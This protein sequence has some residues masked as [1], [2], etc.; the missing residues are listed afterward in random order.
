MEGNQGLEYELQREN[1]GG[2][3]PPRARPRP[4]RPVRAPLLRHRRD[5]LR[6]AARLSSGCAKRPIDVYDPVQQLA[7]VDDDVLDMFGVDTD[8]TGPRLRAGRRMLGGVDVCPTARHAGCRLGRCRSAPGTAGSSARKAGPRHRP[9]ARR[10]ALLRADLVPVCRRRTRH[11][12]IESAFDESM[13]HAVAAPPG[14]ACL[15]GP[16]GRSG[17]PKA[18]GGC[19]HQPIARSSGCSAATCSK[20]ASSSTATTTSSC[21]WPATRARRTRFSTGWSRSTS[22]HLERFLGAV[23]TVHRRHPVRRRPRDADGAADLAAHV[24]RVLQAAPQAHVG[25]EQAA[26]AGE[27]HAALLRRA[28]GSCCRT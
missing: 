18:P 27:D 10:G 20:S 11:R 8:R 28:C 4:A 17:W 1:T 13:W 9:H 2:P 25:A 6:P 19:A 22:P 5:R 16:A 14:A 21:C 24:P 26:G 15:R 23:G 3:E 12:R 7:I